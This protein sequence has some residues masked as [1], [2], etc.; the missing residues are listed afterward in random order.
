MIQ[1][2]NLILDFDGTL[3]DTAPLIIKTMQATMRVMNL[4]LRDNKEC[5]STIGL[6]L[7]EIPEVLWPDMPGISETFTNTY[8]SIFDEL[9]RPLNVVCFPKVTRILRE[10]S[11]KGYRMAVASSRSHKSLCE[12]LEI[13][14]IL[15]YFS[16]I[17]G[18]DDVEI[19]KPSPEPVLTVLDAMGWKANECLVVGDSDVDIRMGKAAGT[20][21]CAVTYGN[22]TSKDLKAARPDFMIPRFSDL[23]TI[24]RP[25]LI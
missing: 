17:V 8:R 18:G 9:K 6:R 1:V 4:P 2:K 3:V 23:L 22:G 16:Y 12:Y 25:H 11:D 13:F 14:G 19:G 10:L 21:T 15:R 7:E 20:I 24:L 5:R